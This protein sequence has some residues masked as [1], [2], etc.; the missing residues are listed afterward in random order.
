MFIFIALQ[1]CMCIVFSI[2]KQ[3]LLIAIKRAARRLILRVVCL[4]Q[5]FVDLM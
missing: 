3:L 1:T 4:S 2:I 5:R